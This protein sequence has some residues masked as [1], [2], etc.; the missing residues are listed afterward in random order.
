MKKKFYPALILLFV[1]HFGQLFAVEKNITNL[2]AGSLAAEF[3]QGEPAAVTKL[4]IAGDMDARDFRFIRDSLKTLEKLDM[5]H[6]N[7]QAY[8]GEGGTQWTVDYRE[9]N[10]TYYKDEIPPLFLY[11]MQVALET[12]ISITIPASAVSI[13]KV[14]FEC[15]KVHEIIFPEN[16]QLSSVKEQAFRSSGIKTITLPEK[17]NYMEWNMFFKCMNLERADVS[18]TQLKYIP[19]LMFADCD[20]LEYVIFPPTIDSILNQAFQFVG[21][22]YKLDSVVMTNPTPPKLDGIPFYGWEALTKKPNLIVP[23]GSKTTYETA[24]FDEWFTISEKDY[25]LAP[26]VLTELEENTIKTPVNKSN[27]ITLNVEAHRLKGNITFN[28]IGSDASLFRAEPAT[29]SPDA[30]GMVK[31]PVNIIFSPTD[32]TLRNVT[33]EIM[34]QSL[35]ETISLNIVGEPI[36]PAPVLEEADNI[37]AKSFTA[38]WQPVL[39][40]EKY[41]LNVYTKNALDEPIPVYGS[42]FKDIEGTSLLVDKLQGSTKYFYTIQA[43]KEVNGQPVYSQVSEEKEVTTLTGPFLVSDKQEISLETTLTNS[44]TATFELTGDNLTAA[45]TLS[46]N[47]SSFDASPSPID[48]Q[49]GEVNQTITVDFTANTFAEFKDTLKIF[50]TDFDVP[51]TVILKGR[52]TYSAPIAKE[53]NDTTQT[54]F[55]ANWNASHTPEKYELNVYTKDGNKEPVAIQGSPFSVEEATS[56]KI[57]GLTDNTEYYYTVRAYKESIENYKTIKYYSEESEEISVKTLGIP[58]LTA[59][60][61]T[62]HIETQGGHTFTGRFTLT[63]AHL[64]SD[65]SLSFDETDKNF[66]VFTKTITPKNGIVNEAIIILLTPD[67]LGSFTGTLN[68]TSEDEV[69]PIKILVTGNCTYPA[70]TALEATDIH[71]NSFNANW[72]RSVDKEQ[73]ILSV[74]TKDANKDTTNIPGSPFNTEV[75]TSKSLDGLQSNT[76]YFYT[77]KAFREV[78]IEGRNIRFESDDSE[79]IQVTISDPDAPVLAA[80]KETLTLTAL[81]SEDGT[82]TFTLTGKNLTEDIALSFEET[83]V[84]FTVAPSSVTPEADGTVN[85]QITVT[86]SPDALGKFE[87]TLSITTDNITD[88]IGIAVTGKTTYPAPVAEDATEVKDISFTANWQASLTPETYKLSVYTKDEDSNKEQIEGSP[89]TVIETSEKITGLTPE[90][91][92]FYTVQ[93]VKMISSDKIESLVSDEIEVTTSGTVGFY[94]DKFNTFIVYPNP[95]KDIVNIENANVQKATIYDLSGKFIKEAFNANQIDIKGIEAGSYILHIETPEG[96]GSVKLQVK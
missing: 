9:V 31:A 63:G 39:A 29:L 68:I 93:A 88:A 20:N 4:T 18:K 46:N 53:A 27:T 34:T 76:E 36:Y 47:N 40:P 21:K 24:G 90:T 70:P 10:A 33:L 1:L 2:T 54:S 42:P 73:Y 12:P 19:R 65:I 44:N 32:L 15:D 5:E 71:K 16:S 84:P 37:T 69:D 81:T 95:A 91:K 82:A 86:F 62:I 52:T 11:G 55:I 80:D 26:V 79:E 59:D 60:E 7:I 6:V 41:E 92:Y 17:V 3:T 87:T 74:Y 13:G 51:V 30:D 50:S 22:E 14:A 61:E 78:R 83:D 49:D 67:S 56:K 8:T 85:K 38:S 58:V 23:T 72:M 96:N 66:K 28:F 94:G 89:F 75:A 77:V 43:V 48:P 35:A 64:T 25:E 57:E 45:I